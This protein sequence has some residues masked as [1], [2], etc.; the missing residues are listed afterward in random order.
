MKRI[1]MNYSDIFYKWREQH[2]IID[3]YKVYNKKLKAIGTL[4]KVDNMT[5]GMRTYI[6][7]FWRNTEVVTTRAKYAP[8][9]KY[10]AFIIYDKCIR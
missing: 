8:E 2:T 3:S 6:T 7:K 1:K 4:Y 9:I 5:A 10:N